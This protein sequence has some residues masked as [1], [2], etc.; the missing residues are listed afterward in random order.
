M[1]NQLPRVHEMEHHGAGL[2]TTRPVVEGTQGVVSAGHPLVSMAGMRMMLDG[3]NAFKGTM[4]MASTGAN[5]QT[6][7]LTMNMS[8]KYLGPTCGDV[9]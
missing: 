1:T 8:G 5:G 9:K 3:G 2:A 6:L 7:N 4:K